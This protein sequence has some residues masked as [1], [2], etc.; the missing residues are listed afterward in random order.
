LAL[1]AAAAAM[2]WNPVMHLVGAD[3]L[4]PAL[5]GPIDDPA[6]ASWARAQW[7]R[8]SLAT[9]VSAMQAACAFNSF[10][11]LGQVDVPT[12]VVVTSRDRIVPAGRQRE[13]A[14]AIPRATVREVDADHAVC[15]TAPELFAP[16]L[17][18]ACR[19]VA[20]PA[21]RAAQPAAP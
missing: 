7:S 16:A 21:P 3:I 14:R 1:P 9:A 13:L 2:W 11:W 19:S 15:I 18:A 12:A 17:L 4:G 6:T 20:E 10:G 8:T 5:L